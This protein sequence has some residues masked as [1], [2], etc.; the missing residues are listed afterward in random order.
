MCT[1]A[2]RCGIVQIRYIVICMH[3]HDE[4]RGTGKEKR[5]RRG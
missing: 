4:T 2:L 1:V 5:A 3:F